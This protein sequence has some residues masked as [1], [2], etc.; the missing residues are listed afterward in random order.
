MPCSVLGYIIYTLD[1]VEVGHLADWK[2]M[3]LTLMRDTETAVRILIAAQKKCEELY[4][5]TE[6]PPLVLL[7]KAGERENGNNS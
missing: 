1:I 4:L 7:P 6:E 3:Y 2:E 5:E